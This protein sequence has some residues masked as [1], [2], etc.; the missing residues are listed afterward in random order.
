MPES[1]DN[2][3]IMLAILQAMLKELEEIRKLLDHMNERE[4]LV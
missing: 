3:V 4:K 1:S 2:T